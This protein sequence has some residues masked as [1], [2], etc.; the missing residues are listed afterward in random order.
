MHHGYESTLGPVMEEAFEELVG[1]N[2]QIDKKVHPITPP[3]TKYINRDHEDQ[4]TVT[5]ISA[6][7][8]DLD[9]GFDNRLE[10]FRSL[11]VRNLRA[12]SGENS[13]E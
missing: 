6:L 3:E 10:A 2:A 7:L 12:C 9:V 4:E 11:Q 13:C 1:V 8:I 5:D